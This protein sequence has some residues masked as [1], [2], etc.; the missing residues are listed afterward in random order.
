MFVSIG[1]IHSNGCS[2]HSKHLLQYNQ[3]EISHARWTTTANGCLRAVIFGAGQITP[4]QRARLIKIASYILSVYIPFLKFIWNHQLLNYCFPKRLSFRLAWNWTW[5]VDALWKYYVK[6]TS[7]WLS[8]KNVTLI[9]HAN[10]S[11]YY[12]EA[13]KTG[14]LPLQV[15]I[16][17]CLKNICNNPKNFFS[18]QSKEAPYIT[19]NQIS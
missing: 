6:H 14:S 13:V 5:T 9:V 12:M 8:P 15:N 19:L 2:W 1:L 3:E 7:Q 11:P 17:T 16:E 10:V 4:D 18:T